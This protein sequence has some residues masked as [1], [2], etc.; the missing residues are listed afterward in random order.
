MEDKSKRKFSKIGTI[1]EEEHLK[2][3]IEHND[4]IKKTC[5]PEVDRTHD[6]E[7]FVDLDTSGDT[8]K[9]PSEVLPDKPK[10]RVSIIEPPKHDLD[11]P[12]VKDSY[13]NEVTNDTDFSNG[14]RMSE[15]STCTLS[16]FSRKASV[17][18]ISDSRRG[19]TWS[20][21]FPVRRKKKWVRKK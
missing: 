20:D 7:L 13:D 14:R 4:D 21:A 12:E 3:N 15:A 18:T 10:R 2:E 6:C 9:R 19:S 11:R 5:L 1:H 16:G 8:E 17:S